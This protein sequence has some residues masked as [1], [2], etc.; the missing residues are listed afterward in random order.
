MFKIQL[1]IL[2]ILFAVLAFSS[3]GQAQVAI[4]GKTIET[5]TLTVSE[6]ERT[7][8]T[9]GVSTAI[10]FKGGDDKEWVLGVTFDLEDPSDPGLYSYIFHVSLHL[11][12]SFHDLEKGES[13][14]FKAFRSLLKNANLNQKTF[15]R[16]FGP[17]DE[18][19]PGLFAIK[20]L[21]LDRSG[22]RTLWFMDGTLS[23]G[24]FT[25][26][27]N[28]SLNKNPSKGYYM[29]GNFDIY[30]NKSSEP[31]DSTG[32]KMLSGGTRHFKL[33]IEEAFFMYDR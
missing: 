24:S 32:L 11:P 16:P 13:L 14:E 3:L 26:V 20:A 10:F 6:G 1:K 27:L 8:E 29:D 19:Q 23:E 18:F 17:E 31:Y 22:N 15:E 28:Y 4:S 25:M 2:S 5:Y 9:T 7:Y 30:L 21:E 33:K 12:V